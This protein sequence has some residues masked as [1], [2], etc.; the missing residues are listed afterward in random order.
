MCNKNKSPYKHW[1]PS[2]VCCIQSM[3]LQAWETAV[4][5]M[6]TIGYTFMKIGDILE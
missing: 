2:Y 5:E 6:H 1:L 4:Y 3:V